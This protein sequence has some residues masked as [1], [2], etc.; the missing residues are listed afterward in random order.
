MPLTPFRLTTLAVL[1][2]GLAVAGCSTVE[3][4]LSSDRVDY[5]S[6]SQ[7]RNTLIVPPDLTQLSRDGRWRP[8]AGGVVSAADYRSGVPTANGSTAVAPEQVGDVRIVRDGNQRWLVTS[9]TPEQLWPQLRS[10]WQDRGFSLVVDNAEVG[11]METDWAENR[12]KIADD[13]I[14]RTIG[15]VLDPLYSTGER[16]KFR[17][18][19][20]R[21][22]NGTEIYLTHRGLEEVYSS[23]RDVQ[24]VWQ[25]RAQDAGLEADFLRR[26]MVQLGAKPDDAK[27]AVASAGTAAASGTAASSAAPRARVVAGAP[28]STLEVDEGFDRAWRR[29]GVALDR[30]GFT[31]EDRDR[32]GGVYYVRLVDPR[33]VGREEPGFFSKLFSFGKDDKNALTGPNRYRVNIK[34]AGERSTVTVTTSQ[35]APETGDAGQ[36]I[37]RMLADELK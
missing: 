36:R 10:F 4:A 19:I 16:D 26:L 12:A 18:R 21:G 24:T 2:L 23:Q 3:E 15:R 1:G 6:Q 37:V 9:M 29:I 5:K 31:V 35:G 30:S 13:I 28:T 34:S 17:T 11:V 20:E 32:S 27:S 25:P 14:R 33:N 22:A 7:N 8:A